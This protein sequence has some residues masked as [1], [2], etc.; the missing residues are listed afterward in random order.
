MAADLGTLMQL[1]RDAL[2]AALPDPVAVIHTA[3]S[4]GYC[5]GRFD[6]GVDVIT[7]P[8]AD[9]WIMPPTCTMRQ[10][11]RFWRA[12]DRLPAVDMGR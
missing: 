5:R 9:D 4:L 2:R 1:N 6:N 11:D 10:A 7:T 12:F 8:D 3:E